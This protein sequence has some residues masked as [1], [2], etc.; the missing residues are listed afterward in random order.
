MFG[1]GI[2]LQLDQSAISAVNLMDADYGDLV[3]IP[4]EASRLDVHVCRKH[5]G[6]PYNDL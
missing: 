1:E 5:Y 6:A 4:Q 3:I 2:A